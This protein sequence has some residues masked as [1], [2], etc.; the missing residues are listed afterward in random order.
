MALTETARQFLDRRVH[1]DK[2]IEGLI[3]RRD[4][5]FRSTEERRASDMAERSLAPIV[6]R[7]RTVEDAPTCQTLR[8][9]MLALKSGDQTVAFEQIG[10]AR[11]MNPDFWEVDRVEGFVR[12]RSGDIGG[13]TK[14][15]ERAYANSSG[16]GRAVVAH[17]FAG[18][19]ARNVK[20]L[21]GAIDY[22]NE[23]HG[24]LQMSDTAAQ[25]GTYLVW[26]NRF[27]EGIALIEPASVKM[28]GKSR[29]I[30]ISSLAEAYRRWA[31]YS[32]SSERNPLLQYDKARKGL[33]IALAALESGVSDDRLRDTATNCAAEAIRGATKA[34]RASGTVPD[35]A[36]WLAY[37]EKALVRLVNSGSWSQLLFELD[38]LSKT[39]NC[40]VAGRRLL[41]LANSLDESLRGHPADLS[42]ADGR[43][44][45]EVVS[46]RE[47]YGF[48]RHPSYP[49]NLFFHADD[50][51]D[52]GGFEI[53]NSGA[54]V[55]FQVSESERGPRATIVE[56]EM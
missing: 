10:I 50:V 24:T 15:Y 23:A 34:L 33:E 18:H 17:F 42:A 12:G 49:D 43:L 27:S 39:R 36:E 31:E 55:R 28:S 30:A 56:R 32:G 35:L 19:L 51:F 44:I 38:K 41:S 1:V 3:T 40:P 25:L 46:I 6:V 54:L 20:D 53:I 47:N 9:A 5:E 21:S 2:K 26:A 37:V 52:K 45:G 7:S 16:E 22:A 14:C 48:V 11:K 8:K 13:A 29:L 4:A